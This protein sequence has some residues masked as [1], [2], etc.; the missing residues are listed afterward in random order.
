MKINELNISAALLAGIAL[1]AAIP[2]GGALAA[3]AAHISVSGISRGY[4]TADLKRLVARGV[5]EALA[6][7]GGAPTRWWFTIQPAPGSGARSQIVATLQAGNALAVSGF[8]TSPSLGTAP[9]GVFVREIHA[10][11][12]RLLRRAAG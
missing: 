5:G 9:S 1:G 8:F 3:P 10:F 4:S 12:A 7:D 6:D 11:A 2:G